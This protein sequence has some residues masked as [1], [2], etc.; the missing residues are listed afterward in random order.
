M[1]NAITVIPALAFSATLLFAAPLHAEVPNRTLLSTFCD[2]ASIKGSTCKRAKAYPNAP[3]GGCDVTLTGDR[4]AGKFLTSRNPLLVA[5]YESG[6][7]A[8]ATDDGGSVVFEQVGGATIFRNF[9]PGVRTNECVTL[10]K[11]ARQDVLVCLTG[12]MGQGLLETGVAQI[13]FAQ[14]AG[15]DV[16]MSFD[17]ILTAEDSIDAYGANVVTC[18]ER[19]KY[20]EL[21]KLAAGPRKATV[22]VD[23]SY[24]D[25]ETIR[26]ACGKGF[27][28]PAQT[29][30]ELAPGDAYVPEG[31]EK[32]G[33]LVVDLV[34][35]KV[36][37]Q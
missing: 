6:C 32:N 34:T 15:K 1:P 27:A 3:R 30:G 5:N 22:T 14:S 25:A 24:A 10:A 17:M 33:K 8:H 26:I 11:D 18:K 7:E 31:D 23:A 35:R 21:S 36:A 9:E 28:K 16:R 19:E 4:F 37:V 13:V 20:F 29:F 2:A 12:H